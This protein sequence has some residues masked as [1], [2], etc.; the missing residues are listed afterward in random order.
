MT[1]KSLVI[2]LLAGVLIQCEYHVS[3]DMNAK[4][5]KFVYDSSDRLAAALVMPAIASKDGHHHIRHHRHS[6]NMWSILDQT[7]KS[8]E[9]TESRRLKELKHQQ[10]LQQ[11]IREEKQ[12]QINCPKCKNELRMTEDELTELRIEYVK[13][14]ILR[15]L[16]LKE[17][18]Q[19]S[20]SNI[21]K[22]VAEG[23]T[24]QL[25]DSDDMQQRVSEEFYAKTTQKIIFPQ[26]GK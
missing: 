25:D 18:P 21:P 10:H 1:T 24:I 19:V 6:P 16:K 26:L 20:V 3:A 5:A 23:A 8:N 14:Q 2:W 13:K 7:V 9:V 4:N 22:P 15:K 17:R 12:A 11:K